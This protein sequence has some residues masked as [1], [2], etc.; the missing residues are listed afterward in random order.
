MWLGCMISARAAANANI[1][2]SLND[3]DG[4]SAR[5]AGPDRR[6]CRA[7]GAMQEGG[8]A[9]R[10][11]TKMRSLWLQAPRMDFGWIDG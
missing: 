7:A 1:S 5:R 9:G 6:S 4:G 10:Q 11:G 3:I 2:L 8:Q